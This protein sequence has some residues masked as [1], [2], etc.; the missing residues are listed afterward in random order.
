M[1]ISNEKLK[2]IEE[3]GLRIEKRLQIAPFAARIYA[4]LTV[5]SYDGLTFEEIR[6]IIGSSKSSTSIN[7]NVLT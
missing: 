7:L 5:S 1:A 3:I 2:L 6:K 4:L